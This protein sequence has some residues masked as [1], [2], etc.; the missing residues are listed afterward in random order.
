MQDATSFQDHR[1]MSQKYN[2]LNEESRIEDGS[3][4]TSELQSSKILEY[5]PT[6]KMETEICKQLN[7]F[8]C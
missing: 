5:G 4:K 3:S 2:M 8:L 1:S 6:K 7:I